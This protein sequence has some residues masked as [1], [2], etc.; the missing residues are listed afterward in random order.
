VLTRVVFLA[1][2]GGALMACGWDLS[3]P[4]DRESPEVNQAIV[5]LDGGDA[6]I[7]AST[8]E[9]YLSTGPCSESNIGTPELLKKRPNGSFDLGLSLFGVGEAFGRR[10]GEEELDAGGDEKQK[11]MRGEQIA[12]ALRV[13][14]VIANDPSS[15]IDLRARARYLEGNLNFLDGHYEEAV[16]AYDKALILAPG[17]A[18]GGDPVGRDAAWNRAIAQKRI[19][20]NKDAGKDAGGDAGG[21]AGS[22]GGDGGGLDSG[23]D[24]GDDSG[25]NQDKDSGASPD[26][27]GSD[28]GQPP[29]E[30]PPDS[31]P[32]PPPR[33]NEDDRMLDQLENAP[34]VQQE[35]AK[36]A[37]AHRKVRGMADK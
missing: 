32:P 35:A 11:A 22:K 14:G 13:L 16:A 37:A 7:A 5:A 1:A 18:D 12:C 34:T 6:T 15:A 26:G 4:F 10:F 21:D 28:S 23:N 30:P 27:A 3:R 17:E 31:G 9:Q 33:A 19:D 29:P 2:A 25:Q 20:D 36:K 8:L 24:S